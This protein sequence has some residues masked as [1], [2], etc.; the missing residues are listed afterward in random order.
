MSESIKSSPLKISFSICAF[1]I[2]KKFSYESV[3]KVSSMTQL[4]H[5]LIV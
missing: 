4:G 3:I 1:I 5:L 2:E